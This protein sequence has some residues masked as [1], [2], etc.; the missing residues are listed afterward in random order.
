M[1]IGKEMWADSMIDSLIEEQEIEMFKERHLKGI[2]TTKNNKLIPIQNLTP[3][4][5]KN[6][7]KMLLKL[8]SQGATAF[9][10]VPIK[11]WLNSLKEKENENEH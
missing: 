6:I 1:G 7:I 8:E 4:H 9:N 10:Y 3:N 2:W 5:R 11:W